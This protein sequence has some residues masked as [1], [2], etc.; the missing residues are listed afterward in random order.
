MD[1]NAQE[2][3]NLEFPNNNT[4]A[5]LDKEGNVDLTNLS[6]EEISK[7]KEINKSLEPSDVNSILN[8]GSDAQNSMEKYS[9]DFLAS[10]RTY[11]S[12]EVGGLINELLTEL[13]YIDVS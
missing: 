4:P 12:G 13:N 10:V 5:K 8:Y 2:L 7:Y 3:S 11:N 1:T 9:N 6:P